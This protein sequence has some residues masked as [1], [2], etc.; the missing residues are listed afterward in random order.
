MARYRNLHRRNGAAGRLTTFV[1]VVIIS[2][3]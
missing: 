3:N 1:I 2:P